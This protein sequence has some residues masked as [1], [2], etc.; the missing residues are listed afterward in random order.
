[1]EERVLTPQTRHASTA[2]HREI[3]ARLRERD[4]AGARA[5]VAAQL[6]RVADEITQVLES[7]TAL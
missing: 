5:A 3:L 2:E 7:K 1:M 6:G 4:A